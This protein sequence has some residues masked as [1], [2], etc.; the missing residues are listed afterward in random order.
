MAFDATVTTDRAGAHRHE[1]GQRGCHRRGEHGGP[2]A[3]DAGNRTA[4]VDGHRDGG[5]QGRADRRAHLAAGVNDP[6]DQALIAVGDPAAGDHH[7]AE[8]GS[9]GPESDRHDGR[10]QQAVTAGRRQLGEDQEAGR[11]HPA[12]Q[13]EDPADANPAGQPG[14]EHS[15]G[16]SHDALRGDGQPGRQRRVMQD[17]LEVDRQDDHL[18]SVPQAEQHVHRAG[19]AE[20]GQP[21]QVGADQRVG[22]PLLDQPEGDGCGHGRHQGAPGYR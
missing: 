8:R 1:R 3:R 5:Q 7:G 14:A 11:G 22:V 15:R 2:V 20:T 10:Q 4:L 17:L 18:A 6:A 19:L 16:E 21:Q 12:G 9:G 13:D